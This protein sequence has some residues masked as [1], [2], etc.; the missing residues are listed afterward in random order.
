MKWGQEKKAM[1]KEKLRVSKLRMSH[2]KMKWN[3]FSVELYRTAQAA[4]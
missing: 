4:Y 3:P 2:F 1:Y